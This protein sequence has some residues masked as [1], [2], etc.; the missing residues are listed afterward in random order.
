M[1]DI[2][3]LG[4]AAEALSVPLAKLVDV[5]S[6]GI[7]KVYE[8]TNIVRNAKARV[9]EIELIS[10]AIKDNLDLPIEYS[11]DGLIIT[12]SSSEDIIQRAQD[13]LTY[14]EIKKQQNLE[15][16]LSN[17]YNALEYEDNVSEENVDDDWIT[18][19]FN[20]S[21][22]V[23]N[24]EMQLLWGQIL[25]G[26]IKKPG[27]Y[28]LRTLDLLK[29]ITQKEAETFTKISS[30]IFNLSDSYFLY[31]DPTVYKNNNINLVELGILEDIGLINLESLIRTVTIEPNIY[32]YFNYNNY[33]IF[34]N[35]QTEQSIDFKYP[36]YRLTKAG[37]E[38]LKLVHAE[39]K[40]NYIRDISNIV[41]KQNIELT[42]SKIV[43]ICADGSIEYQ[44]P[45]IHLLD[46]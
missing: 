17:A 21:S 31:N 32:I 41:K 4:K 22:E 27:T 46:N 45:T 24:E 25:S 26:E 44:I 14:Q 33:I 36:F 38:L 5:C 23:T 15:S 12:S 28:S 34:F 35:N 7:G 1:D 20:I 9:K 2:T 3:G 11:K 18:R 10:S 39:F 19:F 42:Y 16:I 43:Q 29:N 6:K 13:R 37:E 30:Y 8:P 40:E